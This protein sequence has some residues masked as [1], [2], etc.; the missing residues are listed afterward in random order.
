MIESVKH[1][2][3]YV[4][5][6]NLASPMQDRLAAWIWLGLRGCMLGQ[7]DEDQK[8]LYPEES[9]GLE[10]AHCY[11]VCQAGEFR[12]LILCFSRTKSWHAEWFD[13]IDFA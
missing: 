13:L 9:A 7:L 12:K 1:L 11:L 4:L 2:G 10:R 6:D 3:T 8:A 5:A